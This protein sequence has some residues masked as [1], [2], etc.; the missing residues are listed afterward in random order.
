M[1]CLIICRPFQLFLL[2]EELSNITHSCLLILTVVQNLVSS[3]Q[4]NVS[5]FVIQCQARKHHAAHL[6]EFHLSAYDLL[7]WVISHRQHTGA[8][9]TLYLFIYLFIYLNI[10]CYSLTAGQHV[11]MCFD[12]RRTTFVCHVQLWFHHLDHWDR[13]SRWPTDR[14]RRN[15]STGKISL[16][17]RYWHLILPRMQVKIHSQSTPVSKHQGTLDTLLIPDSRSL[18]S[19]S[20]WYYITLNTYTYWKVYVLGCT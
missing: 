11:P 12:L 1:H 17:N 4:L 6:N 16:L 9:V 2:L 18:K 13:Q 20:I 3:N 14:S 15:P 5:N 7:K 10:L 8:C 19:L